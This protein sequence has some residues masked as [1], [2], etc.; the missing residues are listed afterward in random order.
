MAALTSPR[1]IEVFRL[2]TV[3]RA[4]NLEARGMRHSGG[5]I[6]PK[7]AKHFGLSARA[8]HETVIAHID[9]LLVELTR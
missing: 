3:K 4:I 1:D 6:T 9:G 7:W 2:Q 8:P 5:N